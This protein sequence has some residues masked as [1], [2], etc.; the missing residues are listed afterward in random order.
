[1]LLRRGKSFSSRTCVPTDL[2]RHLHR[3]EIVRAIHAPDTQAAK[4]LA[5]QW[6]HR[7]LSLFSRLRKD[8]SHMDTTEIDAMVARYMTAQLDAAESSLVFPG[9]TE[10]DLEG[11][12]FLLQ[13]QL[14]T[15][16]LDL[17]Y[18][19]F[20][21]VRG[22]ALALL[23]VTALDENTEAFRILCRRLL[24]AKHDALW[25]ELN[26]RRGEPLRRPPVIQGAATAAPASAPKSTTPLLSK[27]FADFNDTEGTRR[28]WRPKT[29]NDQMQ[30]QRALLE[31]IGDKPVGDITKDDLRNFYALLRQYPVTRS[32]TYKGMTM[33]QLIEATKGQDIPRLTAKS[34]NSRYIAA[35]K[36]FFNHAERVDWCPKSP[37]VVL[38]PMKVIRTSSKDKGYSLA[39]L[40]TIF[41]S[42]KE[43]A[44]KSDRLGYYYLALLALHSGARL[45]E[46]A[47]LRC[48]DVRETEGHWCIHLDTEGGRSLKNSSSERIVPIHSRVIELGFLDYLRAQKNERLVGNLYADNAGKF[49]QPVTQFFALHLKRV[50][51]KTSRNQNFHSLRHTWRTAMD[52]AGVPEAAMDE[53]GGWVASGSQGRKTYTADNSVPA[54]AAYIE[55]LKLV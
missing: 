20:G 27:A 55:R 23:G 9:Q 46:V 7:L 37:A 28:A 36:S 2:Q 14:E 54:K 43:A 10:D 24:E 25:A 29:R 50:G 33:P 31:C 30:I 21:S 4:L 18:N 1:M 15:T 38:E 41:G 26:A 19:R 12:T 44:V 51:V 5:A 3:R 42:L 8:G 45:D 17:K 40:A 35:L 47:G 16:E 49:G 11:T 32:A 48:I 53:L 52:R 22:D 34:I 13:D 6:Q 39:Q